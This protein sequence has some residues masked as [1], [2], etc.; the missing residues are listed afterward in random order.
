MIPHLF[1]ATALL[2]ATP[3]PPAQPPDRVLAK[4]GEVTLGVDEALQLI[5]S[6]YLRDRLTT[7]DSLRTFVTGVLSRRAMLREAEKLG[8]VDAEI[9][10][11]TA[12][13]RENIILR[14]YYDAEK[15][16]R[17]AEVTEPEAR[18]YYDSHRDEF[19]GQ[20][21]VRVRHILRKSSP[22]DSPAAQRQAREE[23]E[24]LKAQITAGAS[25][26]ALAK[27]HSQDPG[28]AARGG[29][30]GFNPRGRLAKPFEDA[31]F[32]EHAP[33]DV[34]GPIETQFG[35]HL[36]Q[37]VERKP[38]V[39]TPFAEAKEG[40]VRR[41]APTRERESYQRAGEQINAKYPPAID[42]AAFADF[43]R[44]AGV[45]EAPPDGE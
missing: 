16:K 33:G 41:L 9:E 5:R 37:F 24:A 30:L 35:F 36:I 23:A 45:R 10:R 22:G 43:L 42:A 29:D 4:A 18:A 34:I 20:E 44:A 31:M 40:I 1:V 15:A 2:A 32:A 27:A 8:L 11:R 38:P 21:Q 17:P 3:A 28:S 13:F 14:K 19:A 26:E 25:F 6:P 39:P 7:A 12:E